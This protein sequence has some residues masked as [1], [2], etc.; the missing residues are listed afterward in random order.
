MVIT[1]RILVTTNFGKV[2]GHPN[3]PI[4][5]EGDPFKLSHSGYSEGS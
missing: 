5:L 3:S 1:L 2:A 4:V